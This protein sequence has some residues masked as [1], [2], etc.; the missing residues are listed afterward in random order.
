MFALQ[1]G[2]LTKSAALKEQV[3]DLIIACQD[4]ADATSTKKSPPIAAA[5]CATLIKAAQYYGIPLSK[6]LASGISLNP[7]ASRV[8][9]LSVDQIRAVGTC[10]QKSIHCQITGSIND[11]YTY[12]VDVTNHGPDV[13]TEQ[14]VLSRT[15][16]DTNL[17]GSPKIFE[18][19][20]PR[21][22]MPEGVALLCEVPSPILVGE[23]RSCSFAWAPT[24]A[25]LQGNQKIVL[26]GLV[27]EEVLGVDKETMLEKF[28][29]SAGGNWSAVLPYPVTELEEGNNSI[30]ISLQPDIRP[31]QFSATW[32]PSIAF[33][34][35][36]GATSPA[37]WN[38]EAIPYN[39]GDA[40]VMKSVTVHVF[41]MPQIADALA[42]YAKNV[43]SA[44]NKVNEMAAGTPGPGAFFGV[45]DVKNVGANMVPACTGIAHTDGAI[46]AGEHWKGATMECPLPQTDLFLVI[47]DYPDV[48]A[49][50]DEWNNLAFYSISTFNEYKCAR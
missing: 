20:I 36:Q 9:D 6:G 1:G 29:N 10:S 18:G 7:I 19:T 42:Q 47:Y 48:I 50:T 44:E 39:G 13:V 40:F 17:S 21:G 30:V 15:M 14:V 26:F 4:L 23:T 31:W 2:Y 3:A 32:T 46:N 24:P 41:A 43:Q 34:P 45:D 25:A 37:Q 35:K 12:A 11:H 8:Y 38:F 28:N 27:K 22:N 5:T 33:G 16:V 49:E